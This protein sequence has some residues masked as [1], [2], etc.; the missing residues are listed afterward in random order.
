MIMYNIKYL[1][2]IL[3][4]DPAEPFHLVLPTSQI[5]LVSQKSLCLKKNRTIP[6]KNRMT[7]K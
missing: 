7:I 4:E 3:Y 2:E 6:T 5:I 1:L